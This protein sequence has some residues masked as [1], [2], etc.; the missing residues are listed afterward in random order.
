MHEEEITP[1]I[2]EPGQILAAQKDD[3]VNKWLSLE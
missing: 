3:P 2:S 1:I